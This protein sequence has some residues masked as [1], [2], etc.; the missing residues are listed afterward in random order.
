M[1]AC[2]GCS[3]HFL[4]AILSTYQWISSEDLMS[5][6]PWVGT[7]RPLAAISRPKKRGTRSPSTSIRWQPAMGL[8]EWGL[9]P[10]SAAAGRR[11]G[12]GG[13]AP[14]GCLVPLPHS[15]TV[16]HQFHCQPVLSMSPLQQPSLL[17]LC[18][19]NHLVG[20]IVFFFQLH[21]KIQGVGKP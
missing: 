5:S 15:H 16:R 17:S 14:W 7:S 9:S 18:F 11:P 12:E 10:G 4:W 19:P 21:M 8:P 2:G 1:S 6:G 13:W 20:W 3:C